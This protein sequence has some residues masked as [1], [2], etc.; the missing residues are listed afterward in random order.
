MM[1]CKE[2]PYGESLFQGN[3]FRRK[4][5][6]IRIARSVGGVRTANPVGRDVFLRIESELKSVDGILGPV[7]EVEDITGLDLTVFAIRF[8]EPNG[9]ISFAGTVFEERFCNIHSYYIVTNNL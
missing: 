6:W 1:D 9:A 2:S 7:F 3:V 8:F 5:N 4:L